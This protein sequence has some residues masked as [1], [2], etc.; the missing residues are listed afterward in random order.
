[1]NTLPHHRPPSW[2]VRFLRWVIKPD[3]LE[4]IEGDM[5]EVFQEFL[6][7]Y[8]PKKAKRLYVFET[9]KLLRLSLLKPLFL[10]NPPIHTSMLKHN[11]LISY[12]SARRNKSTFLINFVG[13]STGL[14]CVLFIYFWVKGELHMDSFHEH[15]PR[16]YQVLNNYH[17]TE[18]IQTWENS[19]MPLADAL[20]ED[21]PEVETAVF[22]SHNFGDGSLIYGEKS[23]EAHRMLASERFFDLFSFDLI[24][25]DPQHVLSNKNYIVISQALATKLF[26][27]PS[28]AVGKTV[29]WKHPHREW[30]YRTYI[31][32][33]VFAHPPKNNSLKFDV[34]VNADLLEELDQYASQWTSTSGQTYAV[35]K[36]GTDIHQFNEKI[37]YF[38]QE[39]DART[40]GNT[41]YAQAF[42][43]KYLY[44]R[45]ENGLPVGGRIEYVRY[46]SLL[47]MIILLIACINFMNLSTAQAS[48]KMKE[49][50]VKKTMGASRKALIFQFLVESTLIVTL[51]AIA[52]LM[53]V[54]LLKVNFNQIIG[55]TV[56][57]QINFEVIL[58]IGGIVLL[59]GLLAGSYP[60]FYLSGFKPIN[61]LKKKR[62]F[63]GHEQWVRKGLVVV[64]FALSAIFITGV[65]VINRQMDYLNNKHL[66]FDRDHI[67]SFQRPNHTTDPEPFLAE[68]N[69]IP[70]VIHASVM[71]GSIF[72]GY[73]DQSGYSWSG[74]ETEKE[75]VFK[76]PQIGSGVM[77]TLE[78]KLLKGRAFSHEYNNEHTKVIINESAQQLMGLSQP[79][80]HI[81]Q[82]GPENEREIIG[83]VEDFHY[84]SLHQ[85][86]EPLIFRFPDWGWGTNTL[87]K[88]RAGSERA[89][90]EKIEETY[91]AFFT[92]SFFRY[93]FLD[94][95]YQ[96]LYESETR[97]AI[98]SQYVCGLA[99]LIS[100]MGLLGLV[101]FKIERRQ[102]ELGIRKVLGASVVQLVHLLSS[103]FTR[104]IGFAILIAVPTSYLITQ[105]WLSNFAYKIELTWGFFAVAAILT[106][107]IAWLSVGIQMLKA[108]RLNPVEYLRD[109]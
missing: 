5:E 40:E 67:I 56:E 99:I 66:G 60:A 28:A 36:R 38:R 65:L 72:D 14:A 100:C 73:S 7:A 85:K 77:E 18:G 64:Q 82:Y 109:E 84:G 35:L 26:R 58:G 95:E 87:V 39:K 11:L 23:Q 31:V 54:S 92:A 74:Q 46:F 45:Y 48:R 1:M 32:S 59:T 96:T 20:M 55:K 57:I 86:I 12:R 44:G 51:S 79:I 75:I 52:A 15:G 88:I 19:P 34:L 94:D 89:T 33:G 61:V 22:T 47:A 21:F 102:K 8:T 91:E 98:L 10:K 49:I 108:A 53:L 30:L 81:L 80:G 105:A 37:Q 2:P 76:S 62:V 27:T 43:K 107:V 4:E 24:S 63:S 6:E 29:E 50:G 3:Y 9:L 101:A 90:L 71:Q 78:M 106:F 25:G 16:L 97:V 41:L 69:R 17:G 93:S 104:M 42:S 70:G 83:V 13:L 103:D 68:L